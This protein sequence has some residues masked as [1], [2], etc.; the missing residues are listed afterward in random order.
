MKK[1]FF[2]ALIVITVMVIVRLAQ[3]NR[4]IETD[5]G[6]I[7]AENSEEKIFNVKEE[8]ISDEDISIEKEADDVEE[9]TPELT[10]DEDETIVQ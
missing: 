7:V 9:E 1:L 5:A 3:Q 4:L 2:A 8:D 6:K 10:Q